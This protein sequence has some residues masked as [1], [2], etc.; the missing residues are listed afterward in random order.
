MTK[1]YMKLGGASE[2]IDDFHFINGMFV[3]NKQSQ[4]EAIENCCLYGKTIFRA[5]DFPNENKLTAPDTEDDLIIG[6]IQNNQRKEEIDLD[7]LDSLIKEEKDFD[8]LRAYALRIGLDPRI[9]GNKKTLR[10]RLSNLAI[11][12]KSKQLKKE[13]E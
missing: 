4:I 8:V 2:Q 9:A 11:E 12:E 1:V 7:E 6:D 5:E 10:A 3:A 13:Q